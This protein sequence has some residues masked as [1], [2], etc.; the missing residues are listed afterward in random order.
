MHG[1]LHLWDTR[2]GEYKVS[3]KFLPMGSG[4]RIQRHWLSTMSQTQLCLLDSAC[5]RQ[6]AFGTL[7]PANYWPHR[8]LSGISG[9][10]ACICCWR[11]CTKSQR[12]G[13]S[14]APWDLLLCA[15]KKGEVFV[16][17]DVCGTQGARCRWDAAPWRNMFVA[18]LIVS[19]DR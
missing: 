8:D 13:W 19:I 11:H 17:Q 16:S 2:H 15:S 4:D 12:E 10:S 9:V 5:F 7:L 3:G 6:G 18:L 1:P 14:V